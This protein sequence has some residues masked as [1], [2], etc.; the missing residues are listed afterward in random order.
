MYTR[1]VELTFSG[2]D[3]INKKGGGEGGGGTGGGGSSN[4][5]VLVEYIKLFIF[6]AEGS[7]NKW[8]WVK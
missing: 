1:M 2:E 5:K 3:A 8:K 4:K 6:G 7:L